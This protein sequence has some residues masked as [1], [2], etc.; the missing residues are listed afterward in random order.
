MRIEELLKAM[1][2]AFFIITTGIIA[3]M[4]IFCLIFFPDASFSLD[5]IGRILLMAFASDLPFFLFYSRKELGKKQMLVRTAVHIPVLLAILLYFA[6]LW[7]WVSM[8]NPKE[9]VVFILLVLGVYA[10]VYAA[11]AYQDKK[12]ADKLNDSLKERYHS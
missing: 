7:N 2:R 6:H 12:M 9:V 5:D 4:Y 10:I 11:G 1:F 3:S 8:N